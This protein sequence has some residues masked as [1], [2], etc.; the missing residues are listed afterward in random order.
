MDDKTLAKFYFLKGQAYYANGMASDADISE[1]LSSF[2]L[3]SDAEAKS[4][5]KIYSL[6][7]EEMMV[8]MSNGFLDKAQTALNRKDHGT[9]SMNFENA[10][11]TSLKDTLYLFN[12]AL[13]ATSSK[14]YDE[15]LRMYDELMGM[16]YTGISLEFRATDIETG[17]EQTFPSQ[18]IRDISV[19]AGTHEKSRNFT[20]DSKV[21]EMAKNIALIYIEK[22]ETDKALA[23][24]ENAKKTNPDDFNLLLSEANVRYKL[25]EIE[26]Y[27][28]LISKALDL[29]PNN[30]DLLFNLGVVA[31]EAGNFEEALNYYD[32]AIEVDPT[33]VRA[34]MNS[35]ALILDK[36]QGIIDEMNGLGTSAADD[37]KYEELQE[38][39]LNV[40]REAVSYLKSALDNEPNNINAA[41]TL[42]NIYSVLGDTPNFNAM[43]AKVEELES[44]N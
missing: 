2:K 4:G 27:K 36:E 24:I 19:K 6:R 14:K 43:K 18:A 17:E 16:G 42:M 9:S 20:T 38:D 15:A 37:K 11:R 44:G 34:H 39:R 32:K 8:S 31:G 1:A 22:G 13:L 33:Y 26:T 5:K 29:E 41:K 23:A 12:A 28:S 10:Y 35:A 7:A 25:G 21:G 30:V 3:L 40:Y